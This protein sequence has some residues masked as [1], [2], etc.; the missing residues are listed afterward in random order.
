MEVTTKR[1]RSAT[2]ARNDPDPPRPIHRA[3]LSHA[4]GGLGLRLSLICDQ[5][6]QLLAGLEHRHRTRGHL[7]RI[8]GARV[9]GHARLAPADLEGP[10][11]ADLAVVLLLEGVLD[12]LEDSVPHQ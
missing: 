3:E 9:P 5:R 8:A 4:L 10:E 12:R 2:R 1:G 11:A 6:P 7:H